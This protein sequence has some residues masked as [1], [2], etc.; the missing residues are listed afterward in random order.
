MFTTVR[1]CITAYLQDVALRLQRGHSL[2]DRQMQQ[3]AD[4]LRS[5]MHDELQN[6]RQLQD[7]AAL[8]AVEVVERAAVVVRNLSATAQD[9]ETALASTQTDLARLQVPLPSL[10]V[11]AV[12]Y[13]RAN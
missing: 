11:C 4:I 8:S 2:T 6:Q 7:I 3:L 5:Q 1:L 10:C 12:P 13:T 9:A